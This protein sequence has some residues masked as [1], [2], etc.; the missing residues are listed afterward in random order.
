MM[1][2]LEKGLCI[3]CGKQNPTNKGCLNH[4]DDKRL[5]MKDPL[6]PECRKKYNEESQ[7]WKSIISDVLY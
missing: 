7:D 4:T 2:K 6:C 1:E 3:K 5:G